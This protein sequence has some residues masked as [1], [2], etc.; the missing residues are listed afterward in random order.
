MVLALLAAAAA[1]GAA[2]A[3]EAPGDEEALCLARLDAVCA[4]VCAD[5][6]E[7]AAK[8]MCECG[9]ALAGPLRPDAELAAPPTADE[10]AGDASV[11][12]VE[13][14]VDELCRSSL[15]DVLEWQDDAEEVEIGERSLTLRGVPEDVY[16][17]TV[18][19]TLCSPSCGAGVVGEGLELEVDGCSREPASTFLDPANAV[20]SSGYGLQTNVF[21]RANGTD[22][23]VRAILSAPVYDG[24]TRTASFDAVFPDDE[25]GGAGGRRHLLQQLAVVD[26]ASIVVVQRARV[27]GMSNPPAAAATVVSRAALPR[28]A[29]APS[30]SADSELASA[31]E[32]ELEAALD[33]I[34]DAFDAAQANID[35]DTS[36]FTSTF[37][38]SIE[39]CEPDQ[40][41]ACNA[42]ADWECSVVPVSRPLNSVC[43]CPSTPLVM[44]GRRF[45][46]ADGA[47]FANALTFLTAA[48]CPGCGVIN[49]ATYRFPVRFPPSGS[50][51]D[52]FDPFP[53]ALP[54]TF[55]GEVDIGQR[56]SGFSTG[57]V[58]LEFE[59]DLS[60]PSG[61]QA[62]FLGL[63]SI[64][65]NAR[66]ALEDS[67]LGPGEVRFES[68][69][70]VDGGV[71]LSFG[72]NTRFLGPVTI[73]GDVRISG[74]GQ[75]FGGDRL[76]FDSA[77]EFGSPGLDFRLT[78]PARRSSAPLDFFFNGS[79]RFLARI[80]SF[81][82]ERMSI[83]DPPPVFLFSE[84]PE[85]LDRVQIG[86]FCRVFVGGQ[87]FP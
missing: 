82:C 65:E 34:Q 84:V 10:D 45:G 80:V 50:G 6:R 31:V 87:P 67:P 57:S 52:L 43:A 11:E 13:A 41:Q 44:D 66:I 23:S 20:W 54:W 77:V 76:T 47:T 4:A 35:S 3:P 9:D 79:V 58:N 29:A 32:A 27:A 40:C 69:V 70:F 24:T 53:V 22:V 71:D 55:S 42:L 37:S 81:D 8:G 62:R 75:S 78:I 5:E 46:G 33:A 18:C 56:T 74:L 21:G 86:S 28:G 7:H 73:P 49:P 30:S 15:A 64:F 12:A 26:R 63:V 51:D 19:H 39:T 25:A 48:C 59:D 85:G 14:F 2:P 16:V 72:G 60:S 61:R 36:T 17:Y 1:A 38:G 83:T 68:S